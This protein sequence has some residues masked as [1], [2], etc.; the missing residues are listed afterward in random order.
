MCRE[1]LLVEF[2]QVFGCVKVFVVEFEI[3]QCVIFKHVVLAVLFVPV[4]H[5][6]RRRVLE[7][8]FRGFRPRSHLRVLSQA[9]VS[10]LIPHPYIGTI[11]GSTYWDN[12]EFRPAMRV[13]FCG[14]GKLSVPS[15]RA[16]RASEHELA[17]VITQPARRAGRGRKTRRTPVAEAAVGLGVEPIECADINAPESLDMLRSLEADVI[18]VADYGQFIRDAACETARCGTF[19]VHASLLPELRGAAPVNWAILRGCRRTGV[20]TFSLVKQMDAGDIYLQEAVDIDP[21]ETAE[22]LAA[23]LAELGAALAGRTLDL[24]AAGRAERRPQDHAK[25]TFAPVLTKSDG[26]ID[27]SADAEAVRNRIHGTWP[28]PGGQAVLQRAAAGDV[29]VILGRAEVAE[30]AARGEPGVLDEERCLATGAGRLR[31]LQIKPAGK[32]LMDWQAFVNG[33]RLAA[34]DRLIAPEAE[35]GS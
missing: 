34:G 27:W 12:K 28:W 16:V 9:T 15:L 2:V 4:I 35:A 30:G 23:R 3:N 1:L 26:V 21:S 33:A 19:N 20:T 14:S 8:V 7:G 5:K 25:A 6:S 29:D 18:C 22:D 11:R 10:L 17:A 13:I 31:V 32:R 24:L